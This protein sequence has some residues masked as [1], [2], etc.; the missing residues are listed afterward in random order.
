MEEKIEI[1]KKQEIKKSMKMENVGNRNTSE[2]GDS[3]KSEKEVNP[4]K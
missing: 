3:R 2:M 1:Q 4:K